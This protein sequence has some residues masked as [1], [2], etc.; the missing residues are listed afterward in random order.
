MF[1]TPSFTRGFSPSLKI[2]V[3]GREETPTL[4]PCETELPLS[5]LDFCCLRQNDLFLLPP[6]IEFI[7]EPEGFPCLIDEELIK[8][9][10]F[11]GLQPS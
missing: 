5:A 2:A 3:E 7:L 6:E 10:L 11:L 4:S 1:V 8:P 9:A